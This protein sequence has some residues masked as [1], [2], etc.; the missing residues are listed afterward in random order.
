MKIRAEPYDKISYRLL[1]ESGK[2]VG[3]ALLLANGRWAPS[4]KDGRLIA[5]RSFPAPS[6]VA[7]WWPG[8]PLAPPP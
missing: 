2:V 5:K 3:F 8:T 7:D 6:D 1:D 4:D